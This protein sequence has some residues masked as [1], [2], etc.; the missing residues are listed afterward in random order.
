[1]LFSFKD[2]KRGLQMI[3]N[4]PWNVRENLVNLRL[5]MEG[6]SVFEVDHDFMEFWIQVHGIPLDH[7]NKETGILIGG[8][9]GV[10]A[11]AEDLKVNGVLR[12]S[13]SRIRV[14]IN[15]TKALLTGFWLEREEMPPLWVFFKYERLPNSY[16]FN[17]GILGHEK[18]TCKNLTVMACWDL[19]KRKYS[20]GLRVSQVRP[21]S[22]MGGES[23]KQQGWREEEEEQARVPHS[24]RRESDAK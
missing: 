15:I 22:A 19:T 16:C 5:W 1:M 17:C 8:M 10:L 12:R 9:L 11:E 4:G 6:E 20:P 14:S 23:S 21:V 2:R 18:K 7:M 13:F 3:Q 24:L